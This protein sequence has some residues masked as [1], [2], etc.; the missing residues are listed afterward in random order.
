LQ[1]L[2]QFIEGA[3]I[4]IEQLSVGF[5]RL[6]TNIVGSFQEQQDIGSRPAMMR[7]WLTEDAVH[8]QCKFPRL[9]SGGAVGEGVC[10]AYATYS[11]PLVD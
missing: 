1:G 11:P 2:D 6:D 7:L 8:C 3:G 5:L 10:R 9:E 4:A